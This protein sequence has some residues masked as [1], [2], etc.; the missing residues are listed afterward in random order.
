MEEN[1]VWA[2]AVG[3]EQERAAVWCGAE[4]SGAG[5]GANDEGD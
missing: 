5:R 1:A 2:E 3:A 4:R